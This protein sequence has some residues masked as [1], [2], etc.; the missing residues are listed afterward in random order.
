MLGATG[1]ANVLTNGQQIDAERAQAP[2]TL[3][4]IAGRTDRQCRC[5]RRGQPRREGT[6]ALAAHGAGQG[7]RK[8]AGRRASAW[9]AL[10]LKE[11]DIEGWRHVARGHRK[12][13]AAKRSESAVGCIR[14]GD[15]RAGRRQCEI[16]DRF[17]R[18]DCFA[19]ATTRVASPR[20]LH[21]WFR[22]HSRSRLW[23]MIPIFAERSP[24]K[25]GRRRLR[26]GSR[27]SNRIAGGYRNSFQGSDRTSDL[28]KQLIDKCLGKAVHNIGQGYRRFGTDLLNRLTQLK[29]LARDFDTIKDVTRAIAAAGAPEWAKML[30]Y[31]DGYAGRSKDLLRRGATLGTMRRRM[32]SSRE[33]MPG[34]N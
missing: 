20:C 15:R 11:E 2:A 3:G 1:C 14:K 5:L 33:S 31:R 34:R 7:S 23:Q 8:S 19:F 32:R 10:P 28:A 25:S 6:K 26:C 4:R 18:E 29:G 17:M 21:R 9:T 16:G 13:S 12:H 27:R 24:S 22:T 30:E